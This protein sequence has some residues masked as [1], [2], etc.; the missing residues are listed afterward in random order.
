MAKRASICLGTMQF[1]W[2]I[3]E[4]QS[5]TVLDAFLDLGGS[6]IDTA[7]IYS[8]WSS[9]CTVGTAETIMGRWLKGKNRES[10][11]LATKV[12]GR[13]WE[14]E[15][16]EGLSK[17]HILK[18]C[19]DSLGRLQTNYIDLYYAHWEDENVPLLETI[20]TFHDLKSNGFIRDYGLSNYSLERVMDCVLL[21]KENG[22][23]LPKAVQLPF[24]YIVQEQVPPELVRYCE[25]YNIEIVGYSPLAEGF[26]SGKYRRG[27]SPEK[28]SRSSRVLEKFDQVEYW[29]RLD[30]ISAIATENKVAMSDVAHNWVV[31][32]GLIDAMIIGPKTKEQVAQVFQATG[33][34]LPLHPLNQLVKGR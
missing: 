11:R 9:R 1:A 15:D 14:G 20:E 16:G 18:A 24:S 6:F 25:M 13:M 33:L 32:S 17:A 5:I 34:P 2:L 30:D 31:Q 28:T 4:E 3:D 26:L 21:A 7:N 12:R 10:L 22:L 29:D 27:E 23:S 8:S 19:R